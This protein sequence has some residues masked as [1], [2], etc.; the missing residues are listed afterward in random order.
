M[1]VWE[2]VAVQALAAAKLGEHSPWAPR[3]VPYTAPPVTTA[4]LLTKPS[5]RTTNVSARVGAWGIVGA[6]K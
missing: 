3:L 5:I 2:A 6:G 1:V 4:I